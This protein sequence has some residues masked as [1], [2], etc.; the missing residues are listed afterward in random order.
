MIVC[1]DSNVVIYLVEADPTWTPKADARVAAV[2]AAGDEVAVC[3]AA[4]LECLLKP[5]ALAD[6]G[7]EAAFRAFFASHWVR[8]L[9]VTT[10]TWE[11]A[12]QIGAAFNFKAMDSLH[13]ATAIEHG[14]G[15]FL[16]ADGRLGRCTAIPVEVLTGDEIVIMV[17]KSP[18]PRLIE[19]AL[20]IREI[21][22]ESVSDKS[23]RHGQ[24]LDAAPVVR[25]PPGRS[26]GAAAEALP[27]LSRRPA[28]P[29]LPSPAQGKLPSGGDCRV[30]LRAPAPGRIARPL[31]REQQGRRKGRALPAAS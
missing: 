8:M 11:R 16:T 23:L 20:P 26:S 12:A 10:A 3:D 28:G 21:S 5:L 29:V 2:L 24:H 14:C 6:T 9:P 18:V 13:L 17:D 15:L 31:L 27:R 22:A 4:R 19:V 25:P 30:C 1:L 7:A